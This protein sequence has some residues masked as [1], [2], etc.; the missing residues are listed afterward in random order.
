MGILGKLKGGSQIL[1]KTAIANYIAEEQLS[2]ALTQA[3]SF[4]A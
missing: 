4:S 1:A 2:K 3:A